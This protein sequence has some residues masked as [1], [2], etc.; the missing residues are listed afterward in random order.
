MSVSCAVDSAPVSST[1]RRHQERTRLKWFSV[2][3]PQWRWC[4]SSWSLQ[5]AVSMLMNRPASNASLSVSSPAV[6]NASSIILQG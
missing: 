1:P 2:L 5:Q 4:A 3:L 6:I